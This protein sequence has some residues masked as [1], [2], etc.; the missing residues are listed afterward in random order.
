MPPSAL[1]ESSRWFD[2]AAWGDAMNTRIILSLVSA[3][4]LF[5]AAPNSIATFQWLV[6][7]APPAYAGEA[8]RP[9]AGSAAQAGGFTSPP[10]KAGAAGD[11]CSH[12]VPRN[13]PIHPLIIQWW[14]GPTRVPHDSDRCAF[15]LECALLNGKKFPVPDE[16]CRAVMAHILEIER[17]RVPPK[18]TVDNAV[19]PHPLVMSVAGHSLR[20]PNKLCGRLIRQALIENRT[21]PVPDEKCRALMLQALELERS[22]PEQEPNTILVP[23]AP[24]PQP[25]MPG[26]PGYN[27]D[28]SGAANVAPNPEGSAPPAGAGALT[29]RS[30]L[31][32]VIPAVPPDGD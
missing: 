8:D 24:P 31:V 28:Q 3:L 25:G 16:E 4:A 23:N 12:Y 21:V 5:C 27:P 22:E 20:P 6:F 1:K 19:K 30:N 7:G 15:A 29:P 10:I 11:P 9:A 26:A 32:R 14:G 13:N 2:R 17:T 18:I